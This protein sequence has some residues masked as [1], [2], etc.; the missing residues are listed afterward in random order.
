MKI[1]VSEKLYQKLQEATSK[2]ELTTSEIAR[3]AVRK[4]ERLRP[5]LPEEPGGPIVL[6]LIGVQTSNAR[7][8]L[9]WYLE[10][11]KNIETNKFKTNL[12]EGRDYV[13]DRQID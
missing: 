2:F 3:R 1:R 9:E 4:Y 11:H 12:I 7:S 6:S 8:I 5:D 13:V 10:L